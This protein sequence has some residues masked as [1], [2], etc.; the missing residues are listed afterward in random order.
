[1]NRLLF[2]LGLGL[3]AALP[4]A[5]AQGIKLNDALKAVVLRADDTRLYAMQAGDLAALDDMLAPDCLYV[6]SNG[7][8]Q[9]RAE[10]LAALR[11]G[12]LKYLSIRYT[13][14]P[15]VRLYGNDCAIVTGTTQLEVQGADGQR[16]T[17]TVV[18][19]AVYLLLADRWQL[20]SYQSTTAPK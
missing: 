8:T 17:P 15:Q 3:C 20:A 19:T 7:T 18:A 16:H 12:A 14:P 10:F 11:S 9:N 6:H 1:M 5:S 2:I 13:K 4:A